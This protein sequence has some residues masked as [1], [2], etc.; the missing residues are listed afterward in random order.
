MGGGVREE[1]G[2]FAGDSDEVDEGFDELALAGFVSSL[3]PCTGTLAPSEDVAPTSSSSFLLLR[4]L[5]DILTLGGGKPKLKP[6]RSSIPSMF[7][8]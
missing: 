8:V 6:A 5:G 7:C 1:K 2:D 3:S 4:F